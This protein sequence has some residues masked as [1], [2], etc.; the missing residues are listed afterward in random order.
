MQANSV[1]GY[2]EILEVKC[3]LFFL[4]RPKSNILLQYTVKVQSFNTAQHHIL[5]MINITLHIM[6]AGQLF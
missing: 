3:F 6:C 5:F 2:T 1:I 4:I